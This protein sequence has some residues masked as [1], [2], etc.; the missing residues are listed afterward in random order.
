MFGVAT[1]TDNPYLCFPMADDGSLYLPCGT[2]PTALE[3]SNGGTV[4]YLTAAA[5]AYK[6]FVLM[7][8]EEVQAEFQVGMSL[9]HREGEG[10]QALDFTKPRPPEK[11]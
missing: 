3:G 8:P 4:I 1:V 2:V 11:P 9:L 10:P 6:W 5:T 7:S